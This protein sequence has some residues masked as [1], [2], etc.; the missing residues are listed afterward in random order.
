MSQGKLAM[1]IMAKDIKENKGYFGQGEGK[2]GRGIFAQI[3]N[4]KR[5]MWLGN[6]DMK[7]SYQSLKEI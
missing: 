3:K 2:T 4:A 7:R 5:K 1:I 6:F